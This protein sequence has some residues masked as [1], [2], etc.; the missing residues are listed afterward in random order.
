MTFPIAIC[1]NVSQIRKDSSTP[2]Y[3]NGNFI[4]NEEGLTTAPAIW[5]QI[6]LDQMDK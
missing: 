2:N 1:Y 4:F 3:N 5:V 6:V